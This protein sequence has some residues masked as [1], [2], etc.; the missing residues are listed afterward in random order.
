[1]GGG[2]W[3]DCLFNALRCPRLRVGSYTPVSTYL[4]YVTDLYPFFEKSFSINSCR[5]AVGELEMS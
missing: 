4:S 1:M 5:L 3:A 2:G